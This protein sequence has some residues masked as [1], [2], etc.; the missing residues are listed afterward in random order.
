MQTQWRSAA[1]VGGLALYLTG[2]GFVGGVAADRIWFSRDRAQ[3]LH[4]Y[5]DDVRKVHGI[6]IDLERRA[7]AARDDTPE[8]LAEVER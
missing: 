5:E 7:N 2:L 1:L 8:A 6:L 4:R 3:A